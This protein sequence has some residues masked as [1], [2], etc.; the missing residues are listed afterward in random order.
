LDV[1]NMDITIL[2]PDKN[3]KVGIIHSNRELF[4]DELIFS[5][6]TDKMTVADLYRVNLI[7][8]NRLL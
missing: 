1:E 3:A 5:L 2:T 4:P 6:Y 7:Q 8:M